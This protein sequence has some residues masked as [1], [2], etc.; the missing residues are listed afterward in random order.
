MFKPK[1][2]LNSQYFI[3]G[4]SSEK[5]STSMHKM[6]RFRSSCACSIIVLLNPDTPCLCKQCKS[7]SVGFWWSQLIWIC[8]ICHLVCEFISTCWIKDSNWLTIGSGCG[9]LIYSAGRGLKFHLGLCSDASAQSDQSLCC[10]PEE[11]LHPW[12]SSVPSEDSDQTPHDQA[13]LNLRWHMSEGMFSQFVAHIH[14]NLL[15]TLLLGS[16]A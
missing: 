4:A 11:T 7:R 16:K 10:P 2:A 1:H 14:H 9:I 15:I 5:V 8:T 12:L 13:E 3:W 6:C